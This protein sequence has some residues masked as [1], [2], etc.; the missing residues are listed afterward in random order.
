MD[1]IDDANETAEAYLR[2]LIANR[3]KPQP[4]PKG[5]GRCWACKIDVTG[6]R[7]FCCREC[8]DQWEASQP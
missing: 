7:R 8:A 5:N 6:G 3:R 1:E 2:E 4:I